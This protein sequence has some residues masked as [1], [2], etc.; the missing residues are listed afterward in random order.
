MWQWKEK[1]GSSGGLLY[2]PGNWGDIIKGEWLLR[3][4]RFLTRSGNAESPLDYL[5][6][7]AGM[8][9]Y[10]VSDACRGRISAL[11]EG[12]LLPAAVRDYV[13]R[14]RWPGSCTLAADFF[15]QATAAG[16]AMLPRLMVYDKDEKRCGLLGAQAH[17]SVQAVASGWELLPP[18]SAYRLVLVDPYDFLA[19][20]QAMLPRVLRTIRRSPVLL[21]VYN[22]S[23]RGKGQ[24]QDY[25]RMRAALR[26]A[27]VH[28]YWGRVAADSFLPDCWHEMFFFPVADTAGYSELSQE[29]EFAT[30]AVEGA[31]RDAGVF[32]IL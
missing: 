19:E 12:L 17:F 3:V 21:Y 32:G 2:E 18:S 27:G 6:P 20:W 15:A 11:P 9:D 30:R 5:D 1:D 14:G 4:L 28:A 29:L 31:V 22:R 10:P 8:P 23:G 7:F 16:G 26:D 24:L 25:R 13:G